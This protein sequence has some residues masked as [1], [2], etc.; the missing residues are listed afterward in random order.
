[1]T[2]LKEQATDVAEEGKDVAEE[3]KDVAEEGK[4]KVSGSQNGNGGGMGKKILL[5]AAAGVGTIAAGYAARKAPDFVR[6]TL[7]P[8]LEDHGSDE[9]AK[10][11]KQALGKATSGQEGIGKLAGGVASK[12]LGGG[13]GDK[14]KKTRRLPIQRWTDVA[15]PVEKAYEAWTEF[16]KFP[17]FMHRV[18]SVE[19]QGKDSVQWREKIWFSKR[20]WEG[21]VV[22]RKKNDHIAWKTKSGTQ[23]SG[24][25]SF[26]KLSDNL[27]RVMVTVDF[28]PTG[29]IEKMASGLRFVKR[30]VEADLARFKAYVEMENAKGLEY[31]HEQNESRD[32][33]DE[34]GG[35]R[36]RNGSEPTDSKELEQKRRQRAER[37]EQRQS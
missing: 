14:G 10:I 34:D 30:A 28:H 26:H 11:G 36:G 35:Q 3:G 33:S 32:E 2:E 1:M 22:D 29:M 37:R 15:V 9:A 27:T 24:I 12:A 4:D 8:K 6:D 13:G 18:L 21:E 16:D 20:E 23:H 7:L 5:P 31:G 19:K 25:V 17:E